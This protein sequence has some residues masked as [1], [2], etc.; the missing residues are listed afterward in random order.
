MK[1]YYRILEVEPD[2]D[3]ETIEKAYQRL[4]RRYNPQ[5]NPSKEAAARLTKVNEAHQVL[6]Q[7]GSRREYDAARDRASGGGGGGASGDD[8][9]SSTQ[10]L[11]VVIAA[12]VVIGVLAGGV[13]AAVVLTNDDGGDESA[14][15]NTTATVP[16]GTTPQVQPTVSVAPTVTESG[17]QIYDVQVG[18]GQVVES[19]DQEVSVQYTGWLEDGTVFD[20]S[21]DAGAPV[22]F[23]LDE[24]IPGWTEGIPGMQVG[25][26]RRLIIP[27]ELAY[28]EAGRPGIPPNATLT[29]DIELLAILPPPTAAP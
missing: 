15:A 25:G 4:A 14:A 1:N 23:K 12:M 8:G 18:T 6:G 24:V 17:L 26:K 3:Q 7:P 20:T 29:F 2:A 22:P 11:L 21:L 19:A 5:S 27:P 16:P 13:I 28:G 9:L 10:R